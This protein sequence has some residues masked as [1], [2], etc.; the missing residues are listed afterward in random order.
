MKYFVLCPLVLM[1]SVLTT[2]AF[3][4][5]A[6]GEGWFTFSPPWDD[7]TPNTI[8]DMSHLNTKPAGKNGWIKVDGHT[9]IES[10]T[11]KRIRFLGTSV[12]ATFELGLDLFLF[13]VSP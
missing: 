4:Q 7:A 10:N 9:F 6:A 3:A 12:E 8:I 2:T 5:D 13:V 11:G 1:L